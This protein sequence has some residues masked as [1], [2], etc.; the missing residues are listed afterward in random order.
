MLNRVALLTLP[1][2]DS[3]STT[4]VTSGL[5]LH[6]TQRASPFPADVLSRRPGANSRRS[7][8]QSTATDR[9]LQT[10][11]TSRSELLSARSIRRTSSPARPTQCLHPRTVAPTVEPPRSCLKPL[12]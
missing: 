10:V 9:L 7:H 1:A 2:R 8:T 11:R 5:E 3:Q 12:D 4:V 6:P